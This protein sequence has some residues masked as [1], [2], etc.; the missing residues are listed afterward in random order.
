M[1]NANAA[2]PIEALSIPA[3]RKKLS[4]APRLVV[5]GAVWVICGSTGARVDTLGRAAVLS[6]CA[7]VALFVIT[8]PIQ[9]LWGGVPDACT[10]DAS[11]PGSNG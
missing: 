2:S 7:S 1:S 6:H 9:D 4:A 8:E 5:L 11:P 3:L 10:L